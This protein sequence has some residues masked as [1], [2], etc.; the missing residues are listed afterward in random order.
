MDAHTSRPGRPHRRFF[1]SIETLVVTACEWLNDAG[2]RA[3][4][5]TAAGALRT[6]DLSCNPDIGDLAVS[7]LAA[8]CPNVVSLT[9]ISCHRL[10]DQGQRL[11]RR[12]R[13][14]ASKPPPRMA[15]LAR[16]EPLAGGR[17]RAER[18]AMRTVGDRMRSLETLKVSNCSQLTDAVR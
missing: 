5:L 10:T 11:P 4:A 8:S 6:V 1:V 16:A 3:F 14:Q 7:A 18:P 12:R 17:R 15:N 2:V 13:P 9:L